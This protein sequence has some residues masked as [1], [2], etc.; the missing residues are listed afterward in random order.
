MRRAV[1]PSLAVGATLLV[2]LLAGCGGG[3]T[4][5][6]PSTPPVDAGQN[7]RLDGRATTLDLDLLTIGVMADNQVQLG[8]VR[9]AV[10]VSN[11]ARFPIT[12]GEVSSGTVVGTIDH[13]GGLLLKKGERVVTV[14]GLVV[15]TRV[16][17]LFARVGTR[18]MALANLDVGL[19][20]RRDRGST[21]VVT[22]IPATLTVDAAR[23]LNDGL[24][25]SVFVANLPL[26]IATIRA[27][28]AA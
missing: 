12:G 7:V 28:G 10:A 6:G 25:S 24:G 11:R 9:P 13:A 4:Q 23:A 8:A 21:I 18:R 15:D 22:D 16:G 5:G 27:T 26:G 17:Q 20:K 14:S 3:D 1:H 2:L 19:E